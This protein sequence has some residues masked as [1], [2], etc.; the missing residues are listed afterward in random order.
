MKKS[1]NGK[2]TREYFK[3]KGFNIVEDRKGKRVRLYRDDNDKYVGSEKTFS[4]LKERYGSVEKYRYVT[5]V[6]LSRKPKR[7]LLRGENKKG[8]KHNRMTRNRGLFSEFADVRIDDT[9]LK[10]SIVDFLAIKG[11]QRVKVTGFSHTWYSRR[12]A[13]DSLAECEK[14]ALSRCPF[15]P[16]EMI[17]LKVTIREIR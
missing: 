10:Q 8:F 9:T 15:S 6:Y 14:S 7:Q 5:N 13:Q 1:V 17:V 4:K 2:K 3:K 16:E 11:R 12:D